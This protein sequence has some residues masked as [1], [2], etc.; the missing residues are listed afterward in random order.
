MKLF[1]TKES[2]VR[3]YKVVGSKITL[4]WPA[5]SKCFFYYNTI[6]VSATSIRLSI[7]QNGE[8]I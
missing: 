1:M 6:I 5:R 7:I 8:T 3:I 4:A 2:K